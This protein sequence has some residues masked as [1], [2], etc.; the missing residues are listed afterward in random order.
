MSQSTCDFLTGA[1]VVYGGKYFSNKVKATMSQQKIM[2][3]DFILHCFNRDF[4]PEA[5][6][7]VM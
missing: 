2:N 5:D 7:M 4:I 1:T 3:S 6:E